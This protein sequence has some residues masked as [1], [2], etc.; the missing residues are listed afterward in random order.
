VAICAAVG[1]AYLFDARADSPRRARGPVDRADPA[2]VDDLL[3]EPHI[4]LTDTTYGPQYGRV[5]L[6]SESAP[7]GARGLAPLACARVAMANGSG[8]CL[9]ERAGL[10]ST[11]AAEIFD[12]QFEVRHRVPMPGRPSRARMSPD[13]RYAAMTVFV[14]GDSYA[15]A[16]FSTRT[17]VVD[18]RTGE[19][20]GHL[21]EF[22]VTNGGATV[23]AINR[24]YWGVT[25]ADDSDT[26]YATLAIGDDISLIRGSVSSRSATV[27]GEDVECPS[28]SPDGTRVAYKQRYG[29]GLTPIGWH[30]HV[31]DLATGRDVAVT[32]TRSV[33]DQVEWLDDATVL[34]A[35]P[36]G[37]GTRGYDTWAAPADGSGAP[38]VL[39]KGAVS[40][41]VARG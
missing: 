41:S 22:H 15:S 20:L 1:A 3:R 37:D 5:L 16:S 6:A 31:R 28:L 10:V 24:N 32:E 4:V 26:F 34:Y 30:I 25:F 8:V 11:F 18:T 36:S 17:F 38:R 2:A 39:A 21:E 9:T 7:N 14:S 29:G 27:V 12:E 35:L 23:D 33:D 13:G 19:N 40:P